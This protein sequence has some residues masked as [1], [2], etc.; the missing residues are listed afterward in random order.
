[1]HFTVINSLERGRG[2][3]MEANHMRTARSSAYGVHFPWDEL[4]GTRREYVFMDMIRHSA[5]LDYATRVLEA[6]PLWRWQ[7]FRAIKL[8]YPAQWIGFEL[9]RMFW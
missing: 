3:S 4:Q 5:L 7:A 6:T 9:Y 8:L 2:F 1:L